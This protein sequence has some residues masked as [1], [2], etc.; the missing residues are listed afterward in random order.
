MEKEI[1]KYQLTKTKMRKYAFIKKDVDTD[2][3]VWESLTDL[4]PILAKT[5]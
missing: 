1:V 2:V 3:K 5:L 4:L